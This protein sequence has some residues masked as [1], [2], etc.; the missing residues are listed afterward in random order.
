[1]E[2][3]YTPSLMHGVTV[4]KVYWL[5]LIIA[6]EME[7]QKA[8][9]PYS[10]T[11]TGT[12]E[13]PEAVM[14]NKPRLNTDPNSYT[15]VQAETHTTTVISIHSITFSI[16]SLLGYPLTRSLSS[17]TGGQYPSYCTALQQ[18]HQT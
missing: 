13:V 11:P 15:Q 2:G 12:N 9:P 17:F 18:G 6:V 14:T 10:N 4:I 3:G 8:H 16:H 1:M 7:E 5:F